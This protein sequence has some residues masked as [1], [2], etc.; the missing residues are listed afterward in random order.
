MMVVVVTGLCDQS[1]R[2]VQCPAVL[3]LSAFSSGLDTVGYIPAIV[4]CSGSM[5]VFVS[6][7]MAFSFIV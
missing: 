5:L 3:S 6:D 1:L 7:C 4:T 2:A